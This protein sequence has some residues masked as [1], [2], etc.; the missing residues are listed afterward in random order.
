MCTLKD[1]KCSRNVAYSAKYSAVPIIMQCV[2]QHYKET[3]LLPGGELLELL[4]NA[5]SV[6]MH[7]IRWINI[8]YWILL[9]APIISDYFTNVVF[10]SFPTLQ[11]QWVLDYLNTDYLNSQLSKCMDVAIFL[12]AAGK[13]CSGLNSGHWSSA[14][15]ESKAGVCTIFP[16]CYNAFFSQYGI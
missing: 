8:T 12:A 13:R 2:S 4:P 1:S 7:F 16:R 5:F 10:P 6:H 14:T 9:I 15:G 11:V 3:P